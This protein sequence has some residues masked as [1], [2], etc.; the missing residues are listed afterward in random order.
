MVWGFSGKGMKRNPTF[1]FVLV[2]IVTVAG[3]FFVYAGGLGARYL[4]WRL[5]L[6]VVGGSHLV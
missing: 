5:G 6:D 3:G 4:P 1:F 2:L